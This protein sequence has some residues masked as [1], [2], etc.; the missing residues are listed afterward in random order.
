MGTRGNRFAFCG[1]KGPGTFAMSKD[2][3]YH[4]RQAEYCQRQA[5]ETSFPELRDAWLA[6]ATDWLSL[7]ASDRRIFDAAAKRLGTHQKDST[8]EH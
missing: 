7:S 1:M 5:Q 3:D 2:D 6:L 8:A 4:R